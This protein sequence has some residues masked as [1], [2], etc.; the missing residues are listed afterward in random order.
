M[1]SGLDS[2]A[3]FKA[4]ALEIGLSQDVIEL[5]KAGGVTSFGSYAFVTSYRPGQPD[6]T[7]LIEAL[8]KVMHRA[9]ST[10]ETIPL[11]RLFFESCTL[12]ISDLKQ[13]TERDETAEPSRMP[14]AERNARLQEQQIV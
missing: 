8:T 2:H 7:P 11:R 12:A 4:R 10:E 5:L 1:S 13:R 6:E 3:A 9:P 14:V